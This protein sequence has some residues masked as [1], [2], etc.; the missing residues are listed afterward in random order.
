M[1]LSFH[2]IIHEPGDGRLEVVHL[3]D[4]D[5]CQ[6]GFHQFRDIVKVALAVI[7]PPYNLC[8]KR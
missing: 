7:T 4:V 8:T 3:L 1:L 5:P 2:K 6:L